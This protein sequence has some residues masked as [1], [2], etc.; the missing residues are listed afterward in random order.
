MGFGTRN[1]HKHAQEDHEM[2]KKSK[3][4]HLGLIREFFSRHNQIHREGCFFQGSVSETGLN[5][6]LTR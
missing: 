2:A 4:R 1:I 3:S 6:Q 5:G